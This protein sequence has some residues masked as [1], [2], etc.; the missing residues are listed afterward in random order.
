MAELPMFPL[1]SVLFPSVVLPL[2]V[3]EPRYRVMIRHVLDGASEFG[4]CLIERGSEVGGGDVRLGIGT[5]A[6]VQEAAE[7]PD[8]RWALVAVGTRRIL[9]ESWLPDDP[10]PRAE[11]IEHPDPD[12]AMAEVEALAEV[13]LMV[14]QAL[15]KASELGEGA[16]SATVEI[17]SDPVVASHQLAA[18]APIATLDQYELLAA[19]TVGLRL[20]ALREML[21]DAHRLLDLRLAGEGGD[22][23]PG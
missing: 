1:G 9:V 5:V 12:P 4:V 22:P 18:L 14:R 21:H 3:F 6:R 19:P 17:S 11:V 7:L 16:A 20:A 8:G 13:T 2:H 15:A 23:G 10:Y